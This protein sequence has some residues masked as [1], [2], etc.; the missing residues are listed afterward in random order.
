MICTCVGEPRIPAADC[1]VG[2]HRREARLL[3]DRD[4]LVKLIGDN[5]MTTVKLRGGYVLTFPRSPESLADAI[6]AA[7]WRPPYAGMAHTYRSAGPD[8]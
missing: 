7:G 1:E 4:A 5:R 2:D 6:L 3:V 8:A